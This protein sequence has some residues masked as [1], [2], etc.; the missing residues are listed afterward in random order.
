MCALPYFLQDQSAYDI[1]PISPNA[2]VSG[3]RGSGGRKTVPMC[4]VTNKSL[5]EYG[6]SDSNAAESAFNLEELRLKRVS[7]WLIAIGMVWSGDL[8]SSIEP[9]VYFNNPI[10][11]SDCKTILSAY[12]L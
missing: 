11:M 8:L 4:D 1:D 3:G 12:N 5:V 10:S 6:C 2:T 7:Y 9:L